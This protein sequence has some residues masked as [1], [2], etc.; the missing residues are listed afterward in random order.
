MFSVPIC[1]DSAGEH[2]LAG[3]WLQIFT[4]EDP[5]VRVG[6]DLH[7]AAEHGPQHVIVL[8][9]RPD[10]GVVQATPHVQLDVLTGVASDHAGYVSRGLHQSLRHLTD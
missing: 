5:A 7:P 3:F 6:E 2:R 9:Q 8:G 4:K 10:G 1:M